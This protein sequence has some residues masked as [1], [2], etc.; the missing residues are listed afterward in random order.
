MMITMVVVVMR[1]IV[2]AVVVMMSV[3]LVPERSSHSGMS[4]PPGDHTDSCDENNIDIGE[5]DQIHKMDD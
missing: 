3:F 4:D 2:I 1:V 5:V